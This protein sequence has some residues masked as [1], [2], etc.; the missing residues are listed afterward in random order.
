VDDK[1]R[2]RQP[3]A[4]RFAAL[5][6]CCV[7]VWALLAIYEGLQASRSPAEDTAGIHRRLVDPRRALRPR[8]TDSRSPFA[9]WGSVPALWCFARCSG[10]G[11]AITET[12][13]DL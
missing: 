5:R 4:R 3:T 8:E 7:P 12:G 11:R 10:E 13:L 2:R 1:H 6:S 9:C